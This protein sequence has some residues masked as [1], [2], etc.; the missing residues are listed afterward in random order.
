MTYITNNK[1]I[2]QCAE[3]SRNFFVFLHLWRLKKS[4]YLQIW[5]FH[6]IIIDGHFCGFISALLMISIMSVK[7]LTE[8]LYVPSNCAFLNDCFNVS[9]SSF[10]SL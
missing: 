6:C 2:L 5:R 3:Y 7:S 4:G 10:N 1:N 9:I 8:A